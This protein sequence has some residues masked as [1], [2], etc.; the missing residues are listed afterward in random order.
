MDP[1]DF[2]FAHSLSLFAATSKAGEVFE[3]QEFM[4]INNKV[5]VAEFNQAYLKRPLHKPSRALDRMVEHYAR[6]GVPFAMHAPDDNPALGE[7]LLARGFTRRPDMPVMELAG[8][9]PISFDVPGLRVEP[10]ADARTLSDFQR[11]AFGSFGY[12]LQAAPMALTDLLVAL[13]HVAFYVGYLDGQALCCSGLIFTGNVAGIYWV[14][15]LATG[16][17]RGLGAAITAHAA[18]GARARGHLRVCLQA[19]EQGAPVYRRMGFRDVRS[20][21]RFNH[22]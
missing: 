13:P 18:R 6:A 22:A 12:P 4:L 20:Y 15:T 17:R 3:T 8:D 21:L 16:R 1:L 2:N 14:G 5:P 19:S 9:T 7:E 10:V 11:V